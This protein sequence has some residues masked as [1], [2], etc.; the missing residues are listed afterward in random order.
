ML[1]NKNETFL[2]I[3]DSVTDCGRRMPEGEG[4][5]T[6]DAW[7]FGYVELLRGYL[8][9]KYPHLDLRIINKGISGQQAPDLAKRWQKDVMDYKPSVV[10][11]LIGINDVWRKFDATNVDWQQCDIELYEK[12]LEEIITKTLSITK[13]II[14][15]TPF[16]IDNNKDDAMFIEM[17]KYSKV[18]ENL[19]KKYDLFFVDTQLAFDEILKD[20]HPYKISSD[21]IH[22]NVIGHTVLMN[23]VIK[24]LENN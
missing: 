2:L 6:H 22:P 19:A 23:G 1:L 9:A 13:N 21:R 8:F 12:S 20:L 15:Q 5:F 11:I 17:R 7:G 14:V 16:F 4:G 18:C 3:G 10:S 24:V